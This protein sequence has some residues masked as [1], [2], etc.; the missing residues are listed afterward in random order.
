M[1]DDV[2]NV[3]EQYYILSTSSL[4][5]SRTRVLKQGDSFGVYDRSGDIEPVGQLTQGLYHEETRFLSRWA[6]RLS[7]MRPMLL[8]SAVRKDN[9]LLAV[10]LTNPDIQIDGQVVIPRGTLHISR[11]RFLWGG[12]QFES[13]RIANYSLKAVELSLSIQFGADFADIFEVRGVKRER[14]GELLEPTVSRSAVTLS[15]RGLDRVVRRCHLTCSP[16]PQRFSASEIILNASLP[17][18]DEQT[19]SLT[20]SCETG[21]GR[22]P[23]GGY[24]RSFVRAVDALEEPKK[25]EA[26]IYTSNAQLN[27]W[28]NRSSAD[29]H[30]MMTNTPDG[31][32]PYAGVPWFSTV[33]GRDGIITAMECLWSN[34]RL[35][36]G[37][38]SYLAAH[39]ASTTNAEADA[40]PGKILHETR[41]GEMAA[42]N[43]VPF[44]CYYGSVDST[45][46]FVMLAGQ[47]YRRTGDSAFRLLDLAA[48]RTGSELD[49]PLRR[50]RRRRICRVCPA[51]VHRPRATGLERFQRFRFPQRRD[52]GGGAHRSCARCR[53]TFTPPS[54][55]PPK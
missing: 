31:P 25:H 36:R 11:Y 53:D 32:Y 4:A 37:V 42:L 34:P 40:E 10:D 8:S 16:A 45:P 39:Q 38:L 54:K 5:D 1:D 2:I 41:K 9:A 12:A 21:E 52:V 35:A 15:Y 22:T 51:L 17:P 23:S 6:L 43:E 14:R 18:H 24:E 19:Y 3:K 7:K 28:L 33:F 44:R 47:Y 27:A 46:L 29:I 49:R 26:E 48:H 13:L 30:M 55:R 20:V 50:L